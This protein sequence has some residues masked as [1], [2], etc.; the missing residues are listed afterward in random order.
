MQYTLSRIQGA[1]DGLLPNLDLPFVGWLLR[2]PVAALW[3]FN[4]IGRP[5][6]DVLSS[7]VARIMQTPGAQRDAL[8]S[9][10]YVPDDESESLG[11]LE[12]AFL[13]SIEAEAPARAIK[14]AV[15]EGKLTR[16]PA[17]GLVA[18]AVSAGVITEQQG[19]L[20]E[21]AEAA[22]DDAVQV[23][24]FTAEEYFAT[25]AGGAP[26][27]AQETEPTVVPQ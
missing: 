21:V 7:K 9:G 26:Y 1:F 13:L 23:D 19:E 20:L 6:A 27:N 17:G 2:G 15:R 12:R 25:A 16:D 11:R 24:S 3:G 5:P 14:T 10:I 22:R 8:T 18:N 4:P